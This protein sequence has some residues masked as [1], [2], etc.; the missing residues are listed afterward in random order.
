MLIK[1]KLLIF[2]L[3]L[4]TTIHSY[5][6]EK[7]SI[8]GTLSEMSSGEGMI[9]VKVRVLNLQGVGSTSN[10]YGFYSITLEPGDYVLEYRFFGYETIID[11]ISLNEDLSI[12]KELVEEAKQIERVVIT[13]RKADENISIENVHGVGF[14]LRVQV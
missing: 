5:A 8:S 12:N 1:S 3:L 4:F 7:K 14:R 2:F 6:Q 11:S 13:S 9:G 10:E